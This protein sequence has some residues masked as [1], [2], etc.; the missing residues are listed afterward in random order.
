M[1][2]KFIALEKWGF[3]WISL[4]TDKL[5]MLIVKEKAVYL[6]Y[7]KGNYL[8]ATKNLLELNPC[9]LTHDKLL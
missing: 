1:L 9:D 7:G 8:F 5:L 6:F 4:N 3:V 2:D